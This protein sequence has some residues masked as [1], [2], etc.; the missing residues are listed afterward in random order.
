MDRTAGRGRVVAT[1]SIV[2]AD[3]TRGEFG[4]AVASKFLACGAVVP[5]ASAGAGA[6][7]TQSYSNTAFGPDGIRMMREGLSAE[8]ALEKL[9][10]EDTGRDL[11]QVGMVDA[12]G[13]AAAH[14]GAGCHAWA[15]HR[16]GRGFACQGNILAGPDVVAAMASAFE[17]AN[18]ALSDRLLKSLIAGD[19]A[20]GDRRGRQAAAL[21][22]VR[23]KGGYGG[24]NDVLVDLRVDDHP[25]P[26]KELARLVELH[27]LYFGSSPAGEKLAFDRPLLAELQRMMRRQ[28]IYGGP[29]HGD[30]DDTTAKALDAFISA[31]NLEERV[32]FPGR[33]IDRPALDFLRASFP[34][35][36]Q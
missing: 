23:D 29:D 15:G 2:A 24:M 10:A 18:G 7:A 5:W 36:V 16:V 27:R 4:I 31:E 14:T 6:V 13:R 20:G 12:Q 11:R 26:M 35:G 34:D 32:D 17:A 1:F 8:Q 3:V 22:V 21:Y 19:N 28:G 9:I 30:W 33:T 25:D